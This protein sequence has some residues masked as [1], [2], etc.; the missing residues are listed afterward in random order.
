MML[1][2]QGVSS[3]S[4]DK[5]PA[6]FWCDMKRLAI[7]LILIMGLPCWAANDPTGDPNCMAWWRLESGALTTDSS[8]KGHTLTNSGV[9]ANTA[10]YMEGAAS[11][12]FETSSS[13]YMKIADGS[14]DSAFPLKN[15]TSNYTFSI[16]LWM[17][18]ES[19]VQSCLFSKGIDS[20]PDPKMSGEVNSAGTAL[21]LKLRTDI[22]GNH[23]LG[24]LAVS[25]TAG[26]WMFVVMSYDGVSGDWRV[27]CY[28]DTDSALICNET[29]S[30]NPGSDGDPDLSANE[31]YIG[32]LTSPFI[33]EE[34]DG[35]IDEVTV[36]ND[37]L[38][39]EEIVL[40]RD[41]GYSTASS[42]NDWWWRRRHNN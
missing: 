31:F 18:P 32:G 34:F 6:L 37:V 10:D 42:N 19:W 13:D 20:W 40:I 30:L 8:G 25:M 17:K 15:G 7:I 29:A 24:P 39:L 28:D 26:H 38:T 36:F 11:G 35:L 33:T 1:N 12:D 23:S 16:S 21:S 3:S 41:G 4:S 14:L 22:T 5:P 27:Y 2:R 9:D